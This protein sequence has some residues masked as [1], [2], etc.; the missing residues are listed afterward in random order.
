MYPVNPA[1][2]P[3]SRKNDNELKEQTFL[4]YCRKHKIPFNKVDGLLYEI[5]KT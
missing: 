3:A 5:N 1:Y 2:F 4:D